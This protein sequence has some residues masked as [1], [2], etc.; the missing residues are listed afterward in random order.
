[1]EYEQH[2]DAVERETAAI[3]AT[4]R[5][6]PLDARVPTCPAWTVRDLAEHVGEFTGL[7]TH[8]LCEA[9][10][11]PKTPYEALPAGG[12]AGEWYE[13]L[14]RSLVGELRATPSD[15]AAWTWVEDDQSARFIARRCASE[16][17]VHRFD[18][19]SATATHAPF[20]PAHAVD[21]IDEVFVLVRAWGNPPDGSGS[22]LHACGSDLG[23]WRISMTPGGLEV[24]R[25]HADDA[26]LTLRG[27]VSDL[28]LVLFGRPAV[29]G[30]ERIGDDA[31][32]DA[33]RREFDFG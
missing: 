16:L 32:L 3:T 2:I 26:D 9:T 22:V 33:W 12:G 11:R 1:V 5:A 8:V 31:V 7:W 4:L 30:V 27:A 20:D 13:G 28:A 14:A 24:D 23:E 17:A 19:Q 29:G 21:I 10:G 6:T 25:A 18:A 15:S